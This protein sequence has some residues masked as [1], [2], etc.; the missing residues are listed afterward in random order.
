MV[1]DLRAAAR[2]EAGLP[3]SP[4]VETDRRLSLRPGEPCG[5][6]HD[7]DDWRVVV[8]VAHGSPAERAGLSAGCT[9]VAVDGVGGVGGSDEDLAAFRAAC[10]G[11]LYV[12]VRVAET[13]VAPQAA[14]CLTQLV[15]ALSGAKLSLAALE[16]VGCALSTS[17]EL[18]GNQRAV[19]G[20][21]EGLRS[22]CET[23]RQLYLLRDSLRRKMPA[24]GGGGGGKAFATDTQS[25]L[26]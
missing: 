8:D 10:A 21:W 1:R 12:S 14:A 23:L 17:P 18:L 25:S 7:A 15:R 24:G 9:I 26:L 2:V 16:T 5:L 6:V 3:P 19:D 20:A 22:G 4:E 13:V 11:R